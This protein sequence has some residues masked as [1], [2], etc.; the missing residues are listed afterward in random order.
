MV[1]AQDVFSITMDL[2]DERLDTGL[3]SESD[4]ISYK[5]KTPGLITLLQSELIKQGDLFN[6]YEISNYPIPNLLGHNG[7]FDIRTFEGTEFTR[8]CAGSVRAYYFEVDKPAT[9]YI[10]DFN[11]VWNTL[12][13]INAIPT[14]SGYTAYKGVVTPSIG[15]TRSRFRFG[16]TF[17]YRT[18][19]RG[20]FGVPLA[21]VDDVP[22]Y[23]AWIKKTMPVDFK[24]TDEV[25]SE[26]PTTYYG[27]ASGYKWEGRRDLYMSYDYQGKLRIVYRPIPAVITAMTDVLQID[28]VTA[29]TVLPYGVAAHLLLTENSDS[30][31]FFN[32]RYEELKTISSKRQP[33][34][35]ERITNLYGGFE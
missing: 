29:R 8:E 15:A 21:S 6:T 10:E 30:A 7:E 20:L 3:L 23:K 11:G 16:G 31:S 33:E 25:V 1:T 17:Y 12:S 34:P 5:V 19:N 22:E 32:Q 27:Q 14:A 26:T 9:V 28:D 13:T 2:I 18:V 24:S 35:I 4:T